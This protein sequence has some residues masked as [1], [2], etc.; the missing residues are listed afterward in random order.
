MGFDGLYGQDSYEYLRYTNAIQYY[1]TNQTHPGSFY[2]PILYPFLGS[3]LGF[4]FGSTTFAL[5]LISCLSFSFTC[6]YILKSITL[7]YPKS[8]Q[9]FSYILLFAM[10]CPFLLKM[11]LIVMSD[12]LALA[13]VTLCVYY[14][15]VIQ[16]KQTKKYAYALVFIFAT[17]A[18]MTRYAALFIVLPF[19]LKSLFAA[20]TNKKIKQLGLASV[21]ISVVVLPFFIL[22]WDAL[23]K[24]GSNYFLNAW[25][26]SNFFKA[27]FS[28]VDG[29]TS[30]RLP[31]VVYAFSVFF[32]PGFFFI[33]GILSVIWVKN[34]KL[35]ISTI[36]K[37][38]LI[39]VLLYVLFLAG[40]P[41]QNPRI[42]GLV[43]PLVLIILYPAFEKLVHF[44]TKKNSYK[45]V[46]LCCFFIQLF[47]FLW[48]FNSIWYRNILERDLVAL[49]K[50]HQGKTLYSFDIDLALKERNLNFNFK[51]LFKERYYNLQQGELILFY[52]ERFTQQWKNK[53][54]MQNWEFIKTNYFLKVIETHPEGWKL[55][56]IQ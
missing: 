45:T 49:V 1:V 8:K 21:I 39:C 25:S 13:F 42:L 52:P 24:A 5:Q 2:W 44:L 3:A 38:L 28:T 47:F 30:Y 6:V 48:T 26:V 14:Y 33:G 15:I 11:G 41:F 29:V 55:Y 35:Y 23:F 36:H 56:E 7:L 34:Y 53:T 9:Q 37:T 4:I 50:P 54:P 51:N 20:L 10:F 22:Q 40:I 16:N 43:F 12:A 31:N 17:C 46:L 27:S 19:I 32:H 18:I